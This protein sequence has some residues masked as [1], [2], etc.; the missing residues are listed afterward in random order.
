M[1]PLVKEKREAL[2]DARE[3]RPNRVL[4]IREEKRGKH[5]N[6]LMAY[7]ASITSNPNPIGFLS[8]Q[9][10]SF[11]IAVTVKGS[12]DLAMWTTMDRRKSILF[13]QVR[14]GLH[15]DSKVVQSNHGL[16]LPLRNNLRTI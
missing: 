3:D 16:V 13:P 2:V 15:I 9:C 12:L 14:I 10:I 7:R 8:H 4:E 6:R 5:R 11:I 1:C